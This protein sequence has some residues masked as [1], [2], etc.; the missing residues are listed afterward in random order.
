M[1]ALIIEAIP[2]K[3]HLEISGE[4]ALDYKL[5]NKKFDYAWIGSNLDWTDWQEPKIL[6]F[7][8]IKI[9]NRVNKFLNFLKDK[10]I[11]I[12]KTNEI[13][14][15][16]LNKIENWANKFNGNL[17]DL[18]KFS[19]KGHALG[20]GV[21]SSLISHLK[22]DSFNTFENKTKIKKL[23]VSS[24][25]IF[26]R[27]NEILKNKKYKTL[28]T[29]NGR[30]ATCYPI[31]LLAQ[32]YNIKILRHER[33]ANIK[34]YEL[35]HKNIHDYTYVRERIKF[36]WRKRSKNYWNIC[37]SYFLD[38]YKGN[39]IE[40]ER[41]YSYRKH[42]KE[43]YINYKKINNEKLIIFYTAQDYENAAINNDRNQEIYFKKF[44]KI[45]LEEKNTKIIIRVHPVRDNAN[46]TA[47]RK[48]SR[49]ASK[50]VVV[51]GAKDKTDSYK[52]MEIGD[53]IVTYSSNMIVEAAYWGKLSISLSENMRYTDCKSIITVKKFS[54][55]KKILSIKNFKAK[56]KEN[57]F[58]LAYYLQMYGINYK[59]Y[60]PENHFNGKILGINFEWKPKIL[61]NIEKIFPI[62]KKYI[63][64]F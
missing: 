15:K 45:A 27:C 12:L 19:Y 25:I 21:A 37:N 7:F 9:E 5:K 8:G 56:K 50:R 54:Q 51:I 13:S 48:W 33:G 59:F 46:D 31:I 36:Y 49:Y 14:Q 11:N 47:T 44:L 57:C 3:P 26:E 38:R 53:I 30:F 2:N 39:P 64:N 16:T 24:A 20:T 61:T 4:I 32:R 17:N 41:G 62:F 18:Y 34:K 28:I 40:Y 55:I 29:F 63:I 42:Q 22:D 35:F 6:G 43:N 10:K 52:L 1:S 60:K 58:P 23:L